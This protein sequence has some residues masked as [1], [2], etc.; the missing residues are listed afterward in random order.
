MPTLICKLCSNQ[1]EAAYSFKKQCEATETSL[2]QYLKA[3]DVE[4]KEEYPNAEQM[5]E[6]IN[7]MIT[8]SNNGDIDNREPGE[9]LKQTIPKSDYIEFLDNNLVLLTC[10]TCNKI[11]TTLDGLK[12]HKRVHTGDLFKCKIC[13][14][15]YTRLNHLQRHELSH[16]RRKVHVCKICNKTLTRFEHLKRHLVTHLKEKPFSCEKC[17]RGFNRLE[18]LVNHARRCKG[19]RVH[20]CDICNK[21]F[22]RE[23]SLQVHKRIHENKMPVLPTLDNLDNIEEHYF[24]IDTDAID[25]NLDE[26]SDGELDDN[27]CFEPVVDITENLDLEK[28][29]EVANIGKDDK[30][31]EDEK[32]ELK[33][34]LDDVASSEEHTIEEGTGKV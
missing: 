34:K 29:E 11:F 14:K 2:K 21:G 6:D 7:S 20:I 3:F 26:N 4:V 27:D 17:N 16:G 22:N 1:L 24:E 8:A 31:E 25:F 33:I 18:H 15:E 5:L 30:Q 10:R 32:L 28:V 12:C 9:I 13:D 23:D 19:D